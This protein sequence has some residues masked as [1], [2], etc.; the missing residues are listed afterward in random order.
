[1]RKLL[2]KYN[3][4]SIQAKAAIWFAFCS[5]LQKG[6][7]FITVPVFTRLMSTEQYG[8]YSLYLS[9]LQILT[10]VTS[11]YL[12][13]GVF[14]NAMVKYQEDRDR[15]V[16]SM[17]GLTTIITGIV[18]AIYIVFQRVWTQI[19]GLA[20][21]LVILMFFEMLVTPALSF[22]SGKQRF[23]FKY[24]KLVAV[25]LG[26][27]L[28]NPLLGLMAVL[29]SKD[30]AAARIASVVA[31]EVLFC[32]IIMVMQFIRG[33]AFFDKHYWKYALSMAIPLLPHYLSS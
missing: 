21:I 8:T 30:K 22:W 16:A 33:K 29:L 20:P 23:D 19:L 32:G 7:S 11:L 4:M 14:N 25:T 5:I 12:Y 2:D 18:F 28:A 9:W 26:K 6:I 1:M 17:Q 27:S 10:I 15:Y 31:V 13:H 24:K 3:I